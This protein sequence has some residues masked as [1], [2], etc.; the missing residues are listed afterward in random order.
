MCALSVTEGSGSTQWQGP[1]SAALAPP[2]THPHPTHTPPTYVLEHHDQVQ[3]A[4][5]GVHPGVGHPHVVQASA[6]VAEAV[7]TQ[8][9]AAIPG[10]AGGRVG[11]QRQSGRQ[12]QHARA[13]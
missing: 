1:S 9:L 3:H 8:K 4:R 6:R 11:T 5:Q 7:A 13:L 2:P 10:P 12:A